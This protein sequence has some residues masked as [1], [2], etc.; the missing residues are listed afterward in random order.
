M[1]LSLLG[2]GLARAVPR[3]ANFHGTGE[4]ATMLSYVTP[5]RMAIKVQGLLR[6]AQGADA[7]LAKGSVKRRRL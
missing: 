2:T 3:S 5:L 1:K 7:I 6:R 4:T